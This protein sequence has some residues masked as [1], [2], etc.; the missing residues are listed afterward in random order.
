MIIIYFR[1]SLLNG[2]EFCQHKTFINYCLG[3]E[4]ESGKKAVLGTMTHKVLELLA[5]CKKRTQI[6]SNDDIKDDAVGT[7]DCNFDYMLNINIDRLCEKVFDYYKNKSQRDYSKTDLD[8]IKEWVYIVLT[9]QNGNYDPRKREIFSTE[10]HFDLEID[11]PW[12]KYSYELKGEKFSTNLHIK[13][14]IDLIT[15]IDEDTIEVI[16]WKTGASRKNWATGKEKSYEDL[17]KDNQLMFYYYALNK[18]YPNKN[19]IFTINFIRAGGPFTL[20]FD[21]EDLE[22]TEKFIEQRA[23]EMWSTTLPKMLSPR[24]TDFRCTRLCE[25]YKNKYPGSDKNICRFVH[26]HITDNGI[27]ITTEQ[28]MAE[29]FKLGTYSNPGE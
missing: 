22:K 15:S 25:Y 3:I 21:K 13:G 14:T 11:K 26:D 8:S 4:E 2:W 18:L 28:L 16:D 5:E 20:C 12:A 1:S 27:Q 9:Q 7:I 29:G 17:C 10:Q 19:V 23:K 24:Q 6:N